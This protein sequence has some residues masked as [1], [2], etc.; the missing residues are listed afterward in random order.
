MV[1]FTKLLFIKFDC[2]EPVFSLVTES[3]TQELPFGADLLMETP[4]PYLRYTVCRYLQ[5]QLPPPPS[6]ENSR[7]KAS[8]A[9]LRS[10][11]KSN[12]WVPAADRLQDFRTV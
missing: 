8:P 1:G 9:V 5:H 2:R 6:F 4:L 7:T 10:G 11:A 3:T 12:I